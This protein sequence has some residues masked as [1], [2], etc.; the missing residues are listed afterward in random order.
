[1]LPRLPA[2][3]ALAALLIGIPAPPLPAQTLCQPHFEAKLLASD[4]EAGDVFGRSVALDGTGQLAVIGMS[5]DDDL[6]TDAGAAYVFARS[7][8]SW[9]EVQKLL[10]NDGLPGDLLG[11]AVAISSDGS[12]ILLGAQGADPLG[13]LSG[14]AY[15]FVHN[16]TSWVQ[17]AKLLPLDGGPANAFGVSV[18][19]SASGDTAAVGAIGMGTLGSASGAA[20]VFQRSGTAWSQQQKLLAS[21]GAA[22]DRFGFSVDLSDAADR[23]VASAIQGDGIV[24]DSGCAYV[25]ALAGGVWSQ[26]AKLF[27]ADG[28]AN[29]LFGNSVTMNG[30]GDVVA[31]G[32]EWDDDQGQDSGSAYVFRRAGTA[33]SETAKLLAWQGEPFGSF[34]ETVT[35]DAAGTRLLVGSPEDN[36]DRG[37]AYLFEF[38]GAGWVPASRLLALDG[39]AGDLFGQVVSISGD[40]ALAIA[41]AQNVLAQRGASYV[42]TVPCPQVQIFCT[43]KTTSSGCLPSVAA[44]GTPSATGGHFTITVHQA[45]PQQLILLF[46]SVSGPNNQPFQGGTLCV[47]PPVWRL[48]PL[49]AAGMAPCSGAMQ[50]DFNV[51]IASQSFLQPGVQVDAQWW[52]R[53]PGDAF[54]TSL[55]NAIEFTILP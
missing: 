12:T 18:T 48:L 7:G 31:V 49:R 25:F 42:F 27:S 40:G 33:W 52:G 50:T 2:A 20:Y 5:G 3:G 4:G 1:M 14:A 36:G 44:T 29:D 10:A 16:G 23:L 21:D 34:G 32:V 24:A 53:D 22:Q 47:R 55:S 6:G 35:I 13:N 54:G 45:E 9:S 51:T 37:S 19:L 39:A 46:F 17:Q 11:T 30:A 28:A 8:S 41:G 43:A 15:V 38:D 26:E